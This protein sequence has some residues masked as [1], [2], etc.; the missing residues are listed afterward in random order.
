MSS[1]RQE[2]GTDLNVTGAELLDI[3]GESGHLDMLGNQRVHNWI[4]SI[5]I[6]FEVERD[7]EVTANTSTAGEAP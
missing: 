7:A 3:P 1:R 4:F 5:L 2:N 6:P